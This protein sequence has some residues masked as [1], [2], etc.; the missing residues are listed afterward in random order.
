VGLTFEWEEKKAAANLRKQ[1]VSFE[2]AASA[3]GD[4][5]SLTILTHNTPGMKNGG[6][7]SA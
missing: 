6:Y 2:E 3:F 4:P 7:C 1:G 5:L